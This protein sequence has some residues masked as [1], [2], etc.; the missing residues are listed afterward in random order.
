[1][2]KSAFVKRVMAC[3]WNPSPRLAGWET[4]VCWEI[5]NHLYIYLCSISNYYYLRCAKMYKYWLFLD[6]HQLIRKIHTIQTKMIT[7]Q[8]KRPAPARLLKRL[9]RSNWKKSAKKLQT[10]IREASW[11]I[12]FQEANEDRILIQPI[13][14]LC[15]K[16]CRYIPFPEDKYTTYEVDSEAEE[17]DQRGTAPA[18]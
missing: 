13:C 2:G 3:A 7:F 5:P 8:N 12:I 14:T 17:D 6:I 16:K 10:K 15:H 11:E 4:S 1:M 9:Q 18:A